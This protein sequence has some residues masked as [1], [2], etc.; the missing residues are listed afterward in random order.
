MQVFVLM[1]SPLFHRNVALILLD[2]IAHVVVN[3]SRYL[4]LFGREVI[5]EVFKSRYLNVTDGQTT[6]TTCCG[7][8]ALCVAS[9]AGLEET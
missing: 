5:F 7:I 4:K 9:R 6:I 3:V 8:T 2:Q 1:T